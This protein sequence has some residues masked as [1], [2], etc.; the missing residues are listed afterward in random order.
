MTMN[1]KGVQQVSVTLVL[2]KCPVRT[3]GWRRTDRIA[4]AYDSDRLRAVVNAV[5]NLG[6][7]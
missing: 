6:V 7:P 5:R 1:W 2:E 4:L 3:P